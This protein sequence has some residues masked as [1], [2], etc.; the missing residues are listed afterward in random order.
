MLIYL[1]L[2][3]LVLLWFIAYIL[4][5]RDIL[6]PPSLFIGGFIISI[7]FAIY[8]LDLW[9]FNMGTKTFIIIFLGTICVN[10]GFFGLIYYL[11]KIKRNSTVTFNTGRKI[12]ISNYKIIIFFIIQLITLF[13]MWMDLNRI[14]AMYGSDG[15]LANNILLF[16]TNAVMN[17]DPDANFS[18]IANNLYIFSRS[19]IFILI[20]ILINNYFNEKKLNKF[21]LISII[22]G[23]L[24]TFLLGNRGGFIHIIMYVCILI[25]V[26][27]KRKFKWNYHFNKKTIIKLIV[28][29]VLLL[30]LFPTVGMMLAGRVTDNYFDDGIVFRI[31]E[32]LGVYIGAPL[33]LLDLYMYTDA[34]IE[35][36]LP[37]GYA[38]FYYFYNWLSIILDI[39][40]WNIDNFGLEFRRDNGQFLGNVYTV[41]RPF[42]TDLGLGGIVIFSVLS[43]MIMGYLYFKVK[44]K[45][46][47]K[48]IDYNLILYA[49]FVG[50]FGLSFFSNRLIE[51][52]VNINFLKFI[53][54]IKV[55]EYIFVKKNKI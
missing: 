41:F 14:G 45:A 28:S 23:T 13:Y 47:I 12:V 39:P 49:Y 42:Y 35:Y 22:L 40:V 5:K 9:N 3:L 20:Y 50:Q 18:S 10:I 38:T 51:N 53:I 7:L 21:Y 25:Y 33:K 37:F 32:A 1:L 46:F 24:M 54:C 27:K 52:M 19:G 30:I 44:Y 26:F 34:N 4:T 6:S 17:A 11:L 16:R 43:G 8:N 31:I 55:F 2:L 15:S 29:V 36:N 48:N